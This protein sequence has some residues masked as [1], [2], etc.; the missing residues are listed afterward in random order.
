MLMG[1]CESCGV[2]GEDVASAQGIEVSVNRGGCAVDRTGEVAFGCGDAMQCDEEFVWFCV[3][4]VVGIGDELVQE[5]A[6]RGVCCQVSQSVGV[7][8]GPVS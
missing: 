4:Q 2:G 5:A 6:V 3:H 7:C 8:A 1:G